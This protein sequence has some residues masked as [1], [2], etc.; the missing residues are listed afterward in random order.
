MIAQLAGGCS[1]SPEGF[2]GV[3]FSPF[4]DPVLGGA[5]PSEGADGS[6]AGEG[7]TLGGDCDDSPSSFFS[8]PPKRSTS[9]N[10]VAIA[11]TRLVKIIMDPS[12][13][14]H[15][16]YDRILPMEFG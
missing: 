7:A 16:S 8:Q 2:S 1:F 5:L 3:D 4:S 13:N 14:G 6:G 12:S 10:I 11:L 9:P 15:A